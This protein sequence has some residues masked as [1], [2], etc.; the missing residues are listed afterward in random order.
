MPVANPVRISD[1]S[2]F[3]HYIRALTASS[4]RS[5][6]VILIAT[7]VSVLLLVAYRNA[8]GWI[9][10]RMQMVD[11]ALKYELWAVSTTD[12]PDRL[13]DLGVGDDELRRKL[14]LI[15]AMLD[16]ARYRSPEDLKR[17][18]GELERADVEYILHPT[19][20]FMGLRFDINDL[21]ALGGISLVILIFLLLFSIAGEFENVQLAMWK[22]R[23]VAEREEAEAPGAGFDNNN[24]RANLLYHA[25]AMVQ[26]LSRPPTLIR[27]RPGIAHGFTKCLLVAPVVVQLLV[28]VQDWST[29]PYALILNRSLT[30]VNLTVSGVALSALVVLTV[31]CFVYARALDAVWKETFF[32][33][34]P[35]R[36][37]RR[38]SSWLRYVR[39]LPPAP[40]TAKE[41]ALPTE[42]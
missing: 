6:Y 1:D 20:P 42:G 29:R 15:H 38:Q 21:G 33:I 5:R 10:T 13:D 31:L 17:L 28:F 35:E 12:L 26:V 39:L 11:L 24:S 34:N 8:G 41:E 14:M 2:E 22:V 23:R 40:Q 18:A 7:V 3:D 16:S 30:V 25:L 4:N 27:W 9:D 37:E 32:T 36:R 19:V